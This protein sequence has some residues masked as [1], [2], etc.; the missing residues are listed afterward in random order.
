MFLTFLAPVLLLHYFTNPQFLVMREE[1][2]I[3]GISVILIFVLALAVTF[4][5]S[6]LSRLLFFILSILSLSISLLSSSYIVS[7]LVLLVYLGAL[8]ILF[9]YLWM[10]ISASPPI[11]FTLLLFFPLLFWSF[12]SFPLTPSSISQ[13]LFASSLY[14]F[15]VCL[16]FWA[17]VV[18]VLVIDLGLGGFSV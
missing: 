14:L 3:Q 9:G 11:M 1:T 8:I 16:L 12:L 5:S 15:L 2:T 10:Y 17:M 13:L 4:C 6:V 18:V 7:L